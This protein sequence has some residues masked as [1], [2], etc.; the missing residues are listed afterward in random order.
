VEV[1]EDHAAAALDHA[2]GRHG[3]VDAAGQ[4]REHGA[5]AADRQP[6]RPRSPVDV[7]E[8]LRG[9]DFHVNLEL[10]VVE[11]HAR[12]RALDHERAQ[13]AV[14]LHR[15]HR[16]RLEGATRGDPEGAEAAAVDER[17]DDR[18]HRLHRGGDA[19]GDRGTRHAAHARRT[20][21]DGR[22]GGVLPYVEQDA[23]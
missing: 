3:R 10:G 5:A 18:L 11:I 1:H 13:I 8:R 20:L 9:Q 15:R 7:D 14:Q 22:G 2:P 19:P 16:I 4:Q 12:A 21:A 23:P 6:S 17:R